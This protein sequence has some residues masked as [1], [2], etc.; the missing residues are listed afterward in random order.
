MYK[1]T[2]GNTMMYTDHSMS[3]FR[4]NFTYATTINLKIKNKK[5]EKL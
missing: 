2:Y 3:G 5:S 4:M 1:R